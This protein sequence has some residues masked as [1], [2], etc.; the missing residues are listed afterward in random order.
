MTSPETIH[1]T[2]TMMRRRVLEID[3][4]IAR[5]QR[6]RISMHAVSKKASRRQPGKK[7]MHAGI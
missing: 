1:E 3:R 2:I 7:I 5:I 4:M 6:E